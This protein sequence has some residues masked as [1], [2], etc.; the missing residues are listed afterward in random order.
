MVGLVG[1]PPPEALHHV[2]GVRSPVKADFADV[3]IADD[4]GTGLPLAQPILTVEE[5]LHQAMLALLQSALQ[6]LSP[7]DGPAHN[8]M[9]SP[10]KPYGS[11]CA[12]KCPSHEP[13][14]G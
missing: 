6:P 14:P 8:V 5:R 4:I 3:G 7:F 1:V 9:C 2:L 10:G 12:G 13:S 11:L